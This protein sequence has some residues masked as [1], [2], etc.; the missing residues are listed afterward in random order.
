MNE[1]VAHAVPNRMTV[2]QVD[3]VYFKKTDKPKGGYSMNGF[4]ATIGQAMIEIEGR[5]TS[6][7]LSPPR[8][9]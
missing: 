3:G 9:L 5:W 4:H 1:A 8:R 2:N 7:A 6:W